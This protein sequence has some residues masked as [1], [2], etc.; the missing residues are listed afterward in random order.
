M[1]LGLNRAIDEKMDL[2]FTR[3]LLDFRFGYKYQR[4]SGGFIFKVAYTPI[5]PI[6][7]FKGAGPQGL[8]SSFELFINLLSVGIG[9]G[10]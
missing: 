1:G 5:A 4:P 2:N 10:F 3:L 7:Y 6:Y 9:Y 8:L